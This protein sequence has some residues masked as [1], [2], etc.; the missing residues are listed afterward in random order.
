M[1]G[2]LLHLLMLLPVSL[3]LPCVLCVL[4]TLTFLPENAMTVKMDFSTILSQEIAS[5]NA[6]SLTF[7][8]LKQ[9]YQ[10]QI[11]SQNQHVFLPARL[12]LS[13]TLNYDVDHVRLQ[14]APH[15]R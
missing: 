15:V 10:G 8:T 13:L 2:L 7:T 9:Y 4:G 11:K 12:D 6:T 14:D 1:V 3:A 5:A